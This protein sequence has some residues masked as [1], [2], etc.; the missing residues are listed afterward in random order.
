MRARL[1][2]LQLECTCQGSQQASVLAKEGRFDVEFDIFAPASQ[3]LIVP[4]SSPETILPPS[5][6][7]ATL[8]T[9]EPA[10]VDPISFRDAENKGRAKNGQFWGRMGDLRPKT[11]PNPRL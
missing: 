9:L 1:L 2:A 8:R 5:L 7:N 10:F 6:S 11:H 4:E 3:T